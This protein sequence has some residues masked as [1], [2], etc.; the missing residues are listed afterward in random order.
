MVK[1]EADAIIDRHDRHVNNAMAQSGIISG[2]VAR[3]AGGGVFVLD[4]HGIG[5]ERQARDT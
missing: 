5:F 1:D 2:M 3:H 4:A